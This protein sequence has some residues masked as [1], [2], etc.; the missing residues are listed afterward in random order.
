MRKVRGVGAIYMYIEMPEMPEMP[1]LHD[2]GLLTL[3]L[4]L[5]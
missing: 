5:F 3:F 4:T 2:K 1:E